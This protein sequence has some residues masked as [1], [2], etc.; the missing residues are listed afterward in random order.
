M[1]FLIAPRL[2]QN[3]PVTFQGGLKTDDTGMHAFMFLRRRG[4]QVFFLL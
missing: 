3:L 1:S 2:N 4:R